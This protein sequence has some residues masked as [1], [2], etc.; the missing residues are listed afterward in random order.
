[1]S[2]GPIHRI[3]RVRS[4]KH[5]LCAQIEARSSK[6]LIYPRIALRKMVK[7]E[8]DGLLLHLA[9]YI[10]NDRGFGATSVE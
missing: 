8:G 10:P 6:P 7:I 2:C 4:F 3:L 5:Y 1:M 9:L